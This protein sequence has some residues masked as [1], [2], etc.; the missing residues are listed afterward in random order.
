MGWKGIA[1]GA[2]VGA[3]LG[4]GSVFG[5]VLGAWLG[6]GFEER[7]KIRP[8]PVERPEPPPDAAYAVLGASP[9]DSDEALRRKYRELAKRNH[10]D[11]LRARGLSES[12][13]AAATER[14]SRINAAWAAI[15]NE[16]G[17]S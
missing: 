3:L 8:R 5:V 12:Q 2:G 13:V 1:I 10:P 16:R 9:Y 4:H 15:R 14:M 7:R 17:I 6:H 11:V